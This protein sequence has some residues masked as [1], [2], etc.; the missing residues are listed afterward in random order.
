MPIDAPKSRGVGR[1]SSE[2][3]FDPSVV[4]GLQN[5]TGEEK[6][7]MDAAYSSQEADFEFDSHDDASSKSSHSGSR[8]PAS[9]K[10]GV[11]RTVSQESFDP[12]SV[13]GFSH[14]SDEERDWFE[15][16]FGSSQDDL[17]AALV[18]AKDMGWEEEGDSDTQYDLGDIPPTISF[19]P[20]A[21]L[22]QHHGEY[23]DDDDISESDDD[24][25]TTDDEIEKALRKKKKQEKKERRRR[26]EERLRR[27]KKKAAAA[28]KMKRSE[29]EVH[30]TSL[31]DDD[32][33]T[34]QDESVKGNESSPN[35]PTAPIKDDNSVSESP[36]MGSPPQ[37]QK[38]DTACPMRTS[39]ISIQVND[40]MLQQN[41]HSTTQDISWIDDA[42]N[43]TD[44]CD[45]LKAES[46]IKRRPGRRRNTSKVEQQD[47]I[48][49][50]PLES[51]LP[52]GTS[53]SRT[54]EISLQVNDIMLQQQNSHSTTQDVSWIDDAQ[55][56]T[57]SCDLLKAEAGATNKRRPGRKRNTSKVKQQE[58]IP[59]T[60]ERN[61]P[62]RSSEISI[63]V[64]DIILQQNSHSTQ[65]VSWIDNAQ[66]TTD[67]CDLIKAESTA[68]GGAARKAERR[69]GRKRG[70]TATGKAFDITSPSLN[71]S[72]S[73]ESLD[74][75][76]L[77]N[78][79]HE[80]M[81]ACSE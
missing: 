3:S 8:S 22:S 55:N 19:S 10:R 47:T 71:M 23:G 62:L 40:I 5:F 29:K 56:T 48:P 15:A 34:Q 35:T 59:E 80:E 26:K 42:Q 64:N 70:A 6:S 4:L 60:E 65:D 79:V 45:L 1:S 72:E 24:E 32:E 30:P 78:Q 28:R 58:S 14:V 2:E 9:P 76:M 21:F 81:V 49:E 50:T 46:A 53:F 61:H 18:T 57:D 16:A 37:K 44:S 66:N 17:E 68:R 38:R 12:I 7:W 43:T 11:A 74:S 33:G 54:S 73:L 25:V 41:S 69:P 39:E 36:S 77:H 31:L 75:S 20:S 51:D 63:Q 67:S 13:M 52:Q 27:K